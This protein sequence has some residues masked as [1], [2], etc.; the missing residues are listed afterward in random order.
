MGTVRIPLTQGKFALIDEEDF[1]EV[2]RYRWHV[3]GV[4]DGKPYAM[5]RMNR[6]F[7]HR[8]IAKPP[9]GK[10]VDHR[11]CDGL[12]NRRGN[13]RIA[14]KSLNTANQRP[15]RGGTS[16]YKGVYRPRP[17]G[18]WAAYITKDQKRTHLGSFLIEEEAARAYDAAALEL[19]GEFARINLPDWS[20]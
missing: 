14:T 6:L 3:V 4:K 15:K 7:M 19:F 8:L 11:N 17:N 12:D 13:L 10:L 1:E 16:K 9:P 5:N 18:L 20:D 2:S